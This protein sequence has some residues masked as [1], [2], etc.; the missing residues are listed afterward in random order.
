[1]L[2][3][4]T[5]ITI[6]QITPFT[7]NGIS[8]S[9]SSKFTL[10]FNTE[11]IVDTGWEKHTDNCTLKFPK[12]INLFGTPDGIFTYNPNFGL[13]LGAT[14]TQQSPNIDAFGTPITYSPLIMKGDII[15]INDGYLFRNSKGVENYCGTGNVIYPFTNT[16]NQ[17][18]AISSPY[19]FNKFFGYISE[20]K[21]GTPIEIKCEDNFYLLKRTPFPKSVWNKTE[22]G[23]TGTSLYGL[24]NYILSIVNKNYN[25]VNSLYPELTLLDVPTSITA[26]FAL[27]YLEIGD[28]TCGQLL[29]KLKQ[30]YH[31]ESTFRGNVLQFGF[32]I[33]QD[34]LGQEGSA[35]SNNFFCFRDIYNSS[36]NLL[37]S[38]NI[39]PSHDL[40]YK[41]KEDIILSATVQCKVINSVQGK[42][43][44][45][46]EQKTKV[47]KLKVY[48]YWDIVSQ[49]FK[50][51]N[52]SQGQTTST[53]VPANIDGGERHEFYYPVDK[54][55]PS[56][57]ISQLEQ[58]GKDHLRL[59]HYTGFRGC[60]TSFG[61]PFVQWNDNVN[62]LDPIYSD[63]NGQYK[64]KKVVYKGGLKGL[65]QEIHLDYKINVPLPANIN[66]YQLM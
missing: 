42:S 62:I 9:R 63:R 57:S 26:Q 21:S 22:S 46:G 36:G 65:S 35:N 33:Y 52:L 40:D 44:L 30:Q 45:S 43:T 14:G 29:D 61:Y 16:I 47:E 25:Q 58:Y 23:S 55:N 32:P 31:L 12:N 66:T 24:M 8:I 1:M 50:S 51:Q 2:R 11:Y 20:V 10:D 3:P 28:L 4:F 5:Q 54:S 37:A 56:P 7:V 15:T 34:Q 48:V 19:T 59:Y 49:S 53:E 6:Q 64:V 39:F 60:F 38:A 13:I 17:N 27:G 41:N 18:N